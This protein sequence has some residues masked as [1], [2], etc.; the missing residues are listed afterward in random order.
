[1]VIMEMYIHS[2]VF[3]L[4]GSNS[5]G[6]FNTFQLIGVQSQMDDAQKLEPEPCSGQD[7]SLLVVNK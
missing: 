7:A 2:A 6:A 5:N 3:D 1:M 4:G